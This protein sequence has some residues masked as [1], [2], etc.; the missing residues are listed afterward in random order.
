MY[1]VIY[2]YI[3]IYT[4]NIYVMFIYLF[5]SWWYVDILLRFDSIGFC[6]IDTEWWM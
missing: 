3:Y 6:E 4:Q 5:I 1:S 2:I